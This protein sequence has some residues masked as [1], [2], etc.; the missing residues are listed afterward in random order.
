MGVF[1][2]KEEPKNW[3]ITVNCETKYGV[4]YDSVVVRGTKEQAMNCTRRIVAEFVKSISEGSD[5]EFS[6]FDSDDIKGR[7]TILSDLD[8]ENPEVYIE[9]LGAISFSCEEVKV[10]DIF[11]EEDTEKISL[12]DIIKQELGVENEEES[13][14]EH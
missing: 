6:E 1:I 5:F 12:R 3:I 4:D 10:R 8:E 2:I 7:A 14:I 11:F 13:E 9:G